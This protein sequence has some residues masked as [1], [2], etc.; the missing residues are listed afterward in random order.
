MMKTTRSAKQKKTFGTALAVIAALVC[1]FILCGCQSEYIRPRS[2]VVP[3]IPDAT[4]GP[5]PEALPTGGVL[6]A[7]ILGNSDSINPLFTFNEDILNICRFFYEPL[8]GLGASMI[9]EPVLADD[10]RSDDGVNWTIKLRE[11]VV[12]HDGTPLT[13]DDVT[14][15][16]EAIKSGNGAY[17]DC[18]KNIDKIEADG[19]NV[20]I[21]L[22][23]PDG[24]LP[25]KLFFP[26]LKSG[27]ANDPFPAGTGP[28]SVAGA[29]FSGAGSIRFE[30]FG[31]YHGGRTNID[32]F[33]LKFFSDASK[34]AVSGC[35][36][37]I[38]NDDAAIKYGSQLGYDVRRFDDNSLICIVP[39]MY[40]GAKITYEVNEKLKI[41]QLP[42][43]RIESLSLNMRKALSEIVDRERVIERTVSGWGKEYDLPGFDNC[44]FRKNAEFHTPSVAAAE[45]LIEAEGYKHEGGNKNWF[46][47]DDTDQKEPLTINFIV[48]SDDVELIHAC[49]SVV[50]KLKSI[51]VKTT[52]K[53]AAGTEF[54]SLF[55][56]GEYDYT[57]MRL[58]MSFAPDMADAFAN[59]SIFHYNGYDTSW[60]AGKLSGLTGRWHWSGSGTESC[61][62][63]AEEL[64]A[65][66]ETVYAR[67]KEEIPFIGL[68]VRSSCLLFSERLNWSDSAGV[69]SWNLFPDIV[70]WYLV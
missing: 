43:K 39:Y 12:F 19:L 27:K 25:W 42:T 32:A 60:I 59:D 6:S 48:N 70:N 36:I 50:S 18:V 30:R 15:T 29:G 1:A 28:F 21:K 33:E 46:K 4:A 45:K 40:T 61:V 57:F 17:S 67:L 22:K 2:S 54:T 51:G 66:L 53:V 20:N 24:L 52:V 68:Y 31:Q 47:A 38:L 16:V 62:A 56:S 3:E 41:E 9:P 34:A 55:L 5:T 13:A 63:F 11:G 65:G 14:G 23:G 69:E 64:S 49:D 26:I 44:V 7:A 58:S 35:D 8:I 37:V 10:W